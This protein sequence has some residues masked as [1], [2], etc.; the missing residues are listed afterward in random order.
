M[1]I[2]REK[3]KEKENKMVIEKENEIK[4]EKKE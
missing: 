2:I 3:S 1:I 4:K